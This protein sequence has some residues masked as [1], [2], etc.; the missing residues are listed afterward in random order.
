MPVFEYRCKSCGSV[1]EILVLPGEGVPSL[2][3]E[4]CGNTFLEKLL[5][6][7]AISIHDNT[8]GDNGCD[9]ESPCCGRETP[10]NVRPY[11][12]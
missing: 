5:S 7:P 11:Q 4:K 3:C 2:K 9:R 8:I 12:E 1:S 6:A 10:C